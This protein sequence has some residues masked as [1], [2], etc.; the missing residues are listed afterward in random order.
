LASPFSPGAV[1]ILLTSPPLLSDPL[2]SSLSPFDIPSPKYL[3]GSTHPQS[4]SHARSLLGPHQLLPPR[5]PTNAPRLGGGCHSTP[6]GAVGGDRWAGLSG[7][8]RPPRAYKRCLRR[9][10]L[11]L[12]VPAV[13]LSARQSQR[14][15][16]HGSTEGAGEPLRGDAPHP[17]PAASS[18][19]GRVPGD[20]HLSGEWRELGQPT[21]SS[22]RAPQSPAQLRF[23]VLRQP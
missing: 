16:R 22:P 9:S 5:V 15:S 21:P 8:G 18:G 4:S 23:C 3:G 7:R 1:L 20:P 13:Q 10:R 2:Q 12:A 11:L 6:R 19:P 17:L 14:L